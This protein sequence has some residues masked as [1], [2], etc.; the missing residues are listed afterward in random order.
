MPLFQEST[1]VRLLTLFRSSCHFLPLRELAVWLAFARCQPIAA[2][3]VDSRTLVSGFVALC[4][5]V[6]QAFIS[7]LVSRLEPQIY[8]P[9]DTIVKVGEVTAFC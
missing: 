9:R 1:Q 5:C 6:A 3:H 8:S 4:I 7:Q 2:G